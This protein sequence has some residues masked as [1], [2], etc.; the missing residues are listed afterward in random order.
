MEITYNIPSLLT[1]YFRK[2]AS[3]AIPALTMERYLLPITSK[4]RCSDSVED[5]LGKF[6]KSTEKYLTQYAIPI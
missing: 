3:H 6:A 5:Y 2:R 1:F 4:Q